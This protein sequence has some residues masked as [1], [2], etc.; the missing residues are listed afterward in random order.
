MSKD[1]YLAYFDQSQIGLDIDVV[2][3]A[4]V[5]EVVVYLLE[6]PAEGL[7]GVDDGQAGSV[8]AD[9]ASFGLCVPLG[10][11]HQ[12][13]VVTDL[14]VVVVGRDVEVGGSSVEVEVHSVGLAGSGFPGVVVLVGV[15]TL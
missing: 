9:F 11:R 6:V 8:P 10:L 1:G 3:V 5:L 12:E 13:V 2:L 14:A 15:G 4:G 7:V